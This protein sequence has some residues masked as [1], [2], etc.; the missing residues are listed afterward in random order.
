MRLKIT[1]DLF[2]TNLIVGLL[3]S[4][5]LQEEMS[6]FAIARFTYLNL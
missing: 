6:T 4:I 1:N 5:N 3:K 2:Y